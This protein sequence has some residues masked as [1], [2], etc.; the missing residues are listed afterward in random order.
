MAKLQC[1]TC[2]SERLSPEAPYARFDNHARFK[3]MGPMG[4]FKRKDLTMGGETARFC[5]D[6]GYMLLFASDADMDQLRSALA[7]APGGRG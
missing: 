5:L 3:Y 7:S 4:T 2:R 6:C 1:P